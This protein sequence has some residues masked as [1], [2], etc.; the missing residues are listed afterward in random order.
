MPSK[1][2]G[3]AVTAADFLP[4][5]RTLPSL[6]KAAAQCQGCLLYKNASQT[7]FGAGPAG[8]SI[9]LVGE[10][11]G[12]EEDR[13]GEP[14]VGPAGRLLDELL[15]E[16]QIAREEVYLT[17][18]VKHFKFEL[19][20][21]RR[22]HK[23]PARVE[24]LSCRPWLESELS[25]VKPDVLVCLGATAAQAVLGPAIRVTKD[26]G[27]FFESKL[28]ARVLVTYHPSSLLRVRDDPAY[29]VQRRDLVADLKLAKT[30]V[31]ARK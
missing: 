16:A 26:R 25:V 17:N 29:K 4:A 28:C 21:K 7:V 13:L 24:V 3:P 9:V 8:A 19:R 14:F 22:L 15:Q 27:R 5:R 31:A 1:K 10:Q 30:A 23:R 6:K 11:P 2:S 18:A 12:H 20:G